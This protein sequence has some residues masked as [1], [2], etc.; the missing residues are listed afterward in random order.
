MTD[1]HNSNA[2][3]DTAEFARRIAKLS[4]INSALM[5]RVER[6]MGSAGQ[7]VL[8]FPNRD[9]LGKSGSRSDR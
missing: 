1:G 9:R 6:S 3:F 2:N 4:K 5:L 8:A 7:R